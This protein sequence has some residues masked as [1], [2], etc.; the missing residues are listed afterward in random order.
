MAGK[1]SKNAAMSCIDGGLLIP[2]GRR[3]GPAVDEDECCVGLRITAGAVGVIN[4][5]DVA[6]NDCSFCSGGRHVGK[7][8]SRDILEARGITL[9]ILDSSKSV[10]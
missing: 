7:P 4:H 3:A 1:V 8:E 6:V 10:R 2:E 5:F 9:M